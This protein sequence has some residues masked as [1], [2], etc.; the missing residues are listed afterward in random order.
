MKKIALLLI[1]LISTSVGLR[2]DDNA[3][4]HFDRFN[5]D[6]NWAGFGGCPFMGKFGG[7]CG[8]GSMPISM[9]D[10]NGVTKMKCAFGHIWLERNGEL[11]TPYPRIN[12]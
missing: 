6:I 12:P 2:A 8:G 10:A 1:F 4:Q 7:Q 11:V 9:P 3:R 5:S